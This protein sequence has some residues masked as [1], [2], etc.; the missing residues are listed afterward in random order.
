MAIY[1]PY[2][3]ENS[4]DFEQGVANYDPQAVGYAILFPRYTPY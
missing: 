4:Q 2:W 3:P 1:D